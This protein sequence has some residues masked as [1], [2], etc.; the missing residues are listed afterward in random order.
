MERTGW[1]ITAIVF[2]S[3]FFGLLSLMIYGYYIANE[4]IKDTNICYYEICEENP[5]ALLQDGICYCYDY[6]NLNNLIVVN[7]K[8]MD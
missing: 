1:K 5:E 4:E 2:I 8:I 6:D 7:T 3:L